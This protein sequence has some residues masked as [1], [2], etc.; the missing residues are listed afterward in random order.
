ML[1]SIPFA[2][3]NLKVA[4]CCQWYFGGWF[5]GWWLAALGAHLDTSTIG[6]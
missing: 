5:G 6:L 2:G 1:V 3:D 4:V